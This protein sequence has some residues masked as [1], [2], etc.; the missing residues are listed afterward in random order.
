ME[1]QYSCDEDEWE[2]QE[3]S[4]LSSRCSPASGG[5]RWSQPG[6]QVSEHSDNSADQSDEVEARMCG[7]S[8]V[9]MNSRISNVGRTSSKDES[10]LQLSGD[11]DEI[12]DIKEEEIGLEEYISP[13]RVSGDS[14]VRGSSVGWETSSQA[15]RSI[16]GGIFSNLPTMEEPREGSQEMEVIHL[17]EPVTDNL[18]DSDQE[19]DPRLEVAKRMEELD[20]VHKNFSERMTDWISSVSLKQKEDEDQANSKQPDEGLFEDTSSVSDKS[21]NDDGFDNNSEDDYRQSTPVGTKEST[22]DSINLNQTPDAQ[23]CNGS[24]VG[25][26]GEENSDGENKMMAQSDEEVW[27]KFHIDRS[28][29]GIAYSMIPTLAF[30][31]YEE[32]F[33]KA[34]KTNGRQLFDNGLIRQRSAGSRVRSLPFPETAQPQYKKV[35]ETMEQ[36]MVV[37]ADGSQRVDTKHRRE[38]EE[39]NGHRWS[40]CASFMFMIG[41]LSILLLC[42]LV[43]FVLVPNQHSVELRRCLLQD[44]STIPQEAE[45]VQ[46][47]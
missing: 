11:E 42:L 28:Q 44:I 10:C 24:M 25:M 3:A 34:Q 45:T 21:Y 13:R 39:S 15:A 35:V 9:S 18:K 32:G 29:R 20:R 43:G 46:S 1:E 47:I 37:D 16:L 38:E 14:F 6:G 33:A 26:E 12:E 17:N 36:R 2:G 5:T 31:S 7:L 8:T 30:S 4:L 22:N 23:S 40:W 19:E 41:S 27:N